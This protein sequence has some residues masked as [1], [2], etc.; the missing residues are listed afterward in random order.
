MQYLGRSSFSRLQQA[1]KHQADYQAG[2]GDGTI[3]ICREDDITDLCCYFASHSSHHPNSSGMRLVFLHQLLFGAVLVRQGGAFSSWPYRPLPSRSLVGVNPPSGAF[4]GQW[5]IVRHA[6]SSSGGEEAATELSGGS[7]APSERDVVETT[8]VLD[9]TGSDATEVGEGSGAPSR[10]SVGVEST[11]AAVPTLYDEYDQEAMPFFARVQDTEAT[12]KA[13]STSSTISKVPQAPK[14]PPPVEKEATKL[15]RGS[16]IELVQ[17]EIEKQITGVEN[18][19]EKRITSVEEEVEKTRR[20]VQDNIDKTKA[21]VER[22]RQ[23]VVRAVDDI[24]AIPSKVQESIDATTSELE[25]Q[26]Q[27]V[28]RRVEDIKAIPSKVKTS[29]DETKRK[30][31]E[32]V[33]TI[34][35]TAKEIQAIPGRAKQSYFD[36]RDKAYEVYDDLVEIPGKVEKGVKETKLKVDNTVATIKAIPDNVKRGID[37]VT[38]T[39]NAFKD[40]ASGLTGS[41]S[42]K[43]KPK[44]K[45]KLKMEA[46]ASPGKPAKA[47]ET[48]ANGDIDIN[49]EINDVLK[50]AEEAIQGADDVLSESIT[51]K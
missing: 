27:E 24:K 40:F 28:E 18:E 15:K 34:D 7:K 9:P 35:R 39:A 20:Q 21:E 46:S 2:V 33:E 42:T 44:P 11:S 41:K 38:D 30:V 32:T 25:R 22:R 19:I 48:N 23:G 47:S 51:K 49:D 17:G 10:R 50:L 45:P 14:P 5:G 3:A 26:K 31:D 29:V 16:T 43:S 8:S 6:S 36:T 37:A 12:G 4:S 1:K 13:T